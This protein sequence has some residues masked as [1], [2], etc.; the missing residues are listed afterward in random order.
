M[1]CR[2]VVVV[3]SLNRRTMKKYPVVVGV[4]LRMPE[5]LSDMPTGMSL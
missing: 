3:P 5:D 2:D 4:P 1:T